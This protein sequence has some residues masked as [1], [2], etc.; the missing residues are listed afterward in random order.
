M[1]TPMNETFKKRTHTCGD[2]RESHK[3][4]SVVLMGWVDRRRDHGGLIFIDLRDR[5]GRT[6]LVFNPQKN[7]RAYEVAKELKMEYVIAAEGVVNLRPAEAIN[8]NLDTGKIEVEVSNLTILNKAKQTPFLLSES[9]EISEELRLRFRYLDLRRSEMQRNLIMRHK[10]Y[11]V[12]RGFFDQNDFL[13][14]ETPL[15]MK[16]TP[17]GARDYLVP[18]RVQQGRFYALPQSPQT[19]KQILMVAGFDKY[20]QIARCFRDEDL[21]ADRQPEFTQIDVEMSFVSEEDIFIVVEQLMAAIFKSLFNRE[22]ELPI[23]RLSYKECLARYGVDRPD[24]RFGLELHGV[25][26]LLEHSEFRAF[27]ETIKSK[28]IISGLAIPSGGDYSRSQ[29][30]ALNSKAQSLGGKGLLA[31]KVQEGRLVGGSSKFITENTQSLLI[32]EFAAGE[33][34]LILLIADQPEIVYKVL[35]ALRL[36]F[37]AALDLIDKSKK[38]LLWVVDFPLVEYNEEESRFEAIHHP[39]TSPKEADIPLLETDPGSVRARAY[40]LVLNGTE[41]AGGSI[42][43]HRRELQQR[44]FE[45]L[46]ISEEEAQEKFGFLLEALEYGAPPH[47]GIAFGFDRMAMLFAGCSTIRDVIAFPKT[48][49]ALSLMDGAPG[50]VDDRQLKELGLKI[51][52]TE[53]KE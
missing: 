7:G 42:R 6:Q 39:F 23:P 41:I 25:T 5:Y 46:G 20:F 21:R 33:G 44:M 17:E 29:I 12:V 47:G 52:R 31:H 37:A 35:G 45:L 1:L 18:S 50:Y 24:T 19:Y 36:H 28:G 2:L 3:N 43:I 30:D 32:K 14:I 48:A 15:L 38:S 51:V 27:S 49:S 9:S 40:D 8:A 11:Q 4:S 26:E 10:L 34:D 13:E 53:K 16:S 22:I